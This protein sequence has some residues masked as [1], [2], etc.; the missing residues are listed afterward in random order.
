MAN[1]PKVILKKAK[2]VNN[3]EGFIQKLNNGIFKG[4]NYKNVFKEKDNQEKNY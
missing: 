3:R 2:Q 4:L 1:L